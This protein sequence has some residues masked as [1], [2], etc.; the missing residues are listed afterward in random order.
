MKIEIIDEIL[1]GEPPVNVLF[2]CSL[3]EINIVIDLLESKGCIDFSTDMETAFG[4][5]LKSFKIETATI[6][7]LIKINEGFATVSLSRDNIRMLI[8]YLRSFDGTDV[9][10]FIDFDGQGLEEDANWIIWIDRSV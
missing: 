10:T 5:G 8:N 2:T 6:E 3:V 1:F 4:G 7:H 9:H